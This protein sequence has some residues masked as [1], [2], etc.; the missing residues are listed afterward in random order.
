MY[1]LLHWRHPPLREPHTRKPTRRYTL[2]GTMS[3][4][5]PH[6]PRTSRHATCACMRTRTCT[7]ESTTT[8]E[9]RPSSRTHLRFH[10][11]TPAAISAPHTSRHGARASTPALALVGPY[12]VQA[13][14]STR[15][16]AIGG[17]ERRGLAVGGAARARAVYLHNTCI[18]RLHYVSPAAPASPNAHTEQ[19]RDDTRVFDTASVS[20]RSPE[21]TRKSM[22]KTMNI[23][24]SGCPFLRPSTCRKTTA[25]GEAIALGF[26]LE[27]TRRASSMERVM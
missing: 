20:S 12:I 18:H 23:A 13:R 26:G 6:T 1:A 21:R 14:A 9:A 5:Q 16:H 17:A 19:K 11:R 3:A 8:G 4:F 2:R 15:Q 27:G 10:L 22:V 25:P 24:F 7:R